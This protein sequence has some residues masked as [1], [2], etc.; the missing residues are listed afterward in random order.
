MHLNLFY[1]V[2]F[3]ALGWIISG[4]DM[5]AGSFLFD[6]IYILNISNAMQYQNCNAKLYLALAL[7]CEHI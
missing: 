7:L 4:L 3:S 6:I 5:F 1:Y 2:R